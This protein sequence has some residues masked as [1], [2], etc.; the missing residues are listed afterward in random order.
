MVPGSTIGVGVKEEESVKDSWWQLQLSAPLKAQDPSSQQ[1]HLPP[2]GRSTG[3]ISSYIHW[4]KD[5]SGL[6][7]QPWVHFCVMLEK[8]RD[9]WKKIEGDASIVNGFGSCPSQLGLKVE[10]RDT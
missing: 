5:I 1:K 8:G 2:M 7:D 6:V 3:P 9:Q 10:V 4:V